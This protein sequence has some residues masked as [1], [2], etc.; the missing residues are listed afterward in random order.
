[1]WGKQDT[2]RTASPGSS[3]SHPPLGSSPPLE[4]GQDA[5]T[6]TMGKSVTLVL[7]SDTCI[8]CVGSPVNKIHH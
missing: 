6:P 5:R 2:E 8:Q 3:A 1:M 4:E 7:L